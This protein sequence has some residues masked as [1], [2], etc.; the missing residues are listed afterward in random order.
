MTE[1]AFQS[2]GASELHRSKKSMTREEYAAEHRRDDDRA[3][4]SGCGRDPDRLAWM[5]S[6]NVCTVGD[7]A[8]DNNA[9]AVRSEKS[10]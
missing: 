4:P 3:L 7:C 10:K 9:V 6:G 5:L 1:Q 2:A 8:L